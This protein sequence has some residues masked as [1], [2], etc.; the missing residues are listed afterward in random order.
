MYPFSLLL[1]VQ[2][3]WASE[4]QFTGI[5]RR[6]DPDQPLKWLLTYE[7]DDHEWFNFTD[8]LDWI[9]IEDGDNENQLIRRK[10]LQWYDPKP[11]GVPRAPAAIAQ[12]PALLK[13]QGSGKRMK[14]DH[15]PDGR[16]VKAPNKAKAQGAQASQQSYK[17]ESLT[18]KSKSMSTLT[19]NGNATHPAAVNRPTSLAST[20]ARLPGEHPLGTAPAPTKPPAIAGGASF[21]THM[22]ETV[23]RPATRPATTAAAPVAPTAPIRLGKL[24]PRPITS[25]SATGLASA[26]VPSATIATLDPAKAAA[27]PL[28]RKLGEGIPTVPKKEQRPTTK[29]LNANGTVAV[30]PAAR[31]P[32]ELQHNTSSGSKPIGSSPPVRNALGSGGM[33]K[34]HEEG[35]VR[36]RMAPAQPGGPMPTSTAPVVG[37]VSVPGAPPHTAAASTAA[38][39]AAAASRMR[40]GYS[41]TGE[42]GDDNEPPARTSTQVSAPSRT[43]LAPTVTRLPAKNLNAP[44][45]SLTS[46]ATAQKTVAVTRLPRAGSSNLTTSILLGAGPAAPQ[47]AFLPHSIGL[48]SA[49]GTVSATDLA[50]GGGGL[51][52]TPLGP[53]PDINDDYAAARRTASGPQL[54]E[55]PVNQ[56][57][58]QQPPFGGFVLAGGRSASTGAAPTQD[59]DLF[60]ASGGMIGGVASAVAG[61]RQGPTPNVTSFKAPP[62]AYSTL[63]QSVA[64]GSAGAGKGPA[65]K[66]ATTSIVMSKQRRLEVC[67]EHMHSSN[68]SIRVGHSS[69]SNSCWTGLL[70]RRCSWFRG[71]Q[72][73]SQSVSLEN[74][75]LKCLQVCAS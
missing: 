69:G 48:G 61:S 74:Y 16:S 50:T 64:S 39:A 10:V 23:L 56:Q 67:F 1:P 45:L 33:L 36:P 24:A 7:D 26:A 47:T 13:R 70:L 62:S 53:S 73:Y 66:S 58:H 29:L 20:V 3:D 55:Y 63:I 54:D 17:P 8:T 9:E 57:K 11:P 15:S 2:T 18:S 30:Q 43:T 71:I 14:Q 6:Y 12:A 5:I 75:T 34:A 68:N 59:M 60:L 52:D 31:K 19:M 46:S 22:A 51:H 35:Q 21:Y 4:G 72:C 65:G 38:A 32:Q 44:H 42:D 27:G 37:L 41:R 40:P 28:K 49:L 25:L